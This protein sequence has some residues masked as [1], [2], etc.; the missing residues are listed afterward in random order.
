MKINKEN[1]G[2]KDIYINICKIYVKYR[3]IHKMK[4]YYT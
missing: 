4:K 2:N 1:K 3:N